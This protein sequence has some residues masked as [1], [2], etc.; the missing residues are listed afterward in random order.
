LVAAYGLDLEALKAF[1][2]AADG[3]LFKR[4]SSGF[5]SMLNQ[6]TRDVLGTETNTGLSF[7]SLRHSISGLMKAAVTPDSIMQAITG[8]SA[9]NITNDLYARTQRLPVEV[10][11][12][13][14]VKAFNLTEQNH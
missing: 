14:L 5:T 6:L 11:H 4:S 10:I 2:E 9:G 13:A 8:H 1:A 3:K 12:A 7:H